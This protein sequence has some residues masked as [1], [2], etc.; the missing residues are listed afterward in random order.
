MLRLSSLLILTLIA[1]GKSATKPAPELT[2]SSSRTGTDAAAG[3]GGDA[4]SGSS[5][6]SLDIEPT[7]PPPTPTIKK[8]AHGD[9]KTEYASKPTRDPN[10]MCKIAGGT[11]M[12]GAPDSDKD[13]RPEDRP[14]HEVFVSPYYIDQFEVTN[15]QIVHYLNATKNNECTPRHKLDIT[16]ARHCFELAKWTEPDGRTLTSTVDLE[17]VDG[18]YRV[19]DPGKARHPMRSASPE[20]AKR[21]CQ[22]VGKRLVTEA[23]WEFAA[24][25]DPASHRDL[26]YPWGDRFDRNRVSCDDDGCKDRGS[27]L[28]VGSFDGT[29]GLKD[30]SSPWGVHD[31]GMN[32]DEMVADCYAPY[33]P[34]SGPCRDPLVSGQVSCEIVRRGLAVPKFAIT[35]RWE[36]SSSDVL[37]FRCARS[38]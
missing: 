34:C 11:F 22:W 23:Q 27:K 25:H 31:L 16:G 4:G 7:V 6:V 10:P 12:M 21:Y 20:G 32:A 2:G 28:S 8:A 29:N 9:C 33:K 17:L 1:C 5:A 37:G 30:G 24:R 14:V 19:A 38:D 35:S 18:A 3:P 13:A 15:Q 36:Q 26:R